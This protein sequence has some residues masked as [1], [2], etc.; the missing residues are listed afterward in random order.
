MTMIKDGK[1]VPVKQDK[2]KPDKK[3][4]QGGVGLITRPLYL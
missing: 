4:Q 1:R 3:K 2:K